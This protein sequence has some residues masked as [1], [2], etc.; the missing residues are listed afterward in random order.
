MRA[1]LGDHPYRLQERGDLGARLRAAFD[2]HFDGG[3][4][5]VVAI[6]A[7]CPAVDAAVI[8]EAERRLRSVDVVI[9]PSE[10]GGYYLI[11]LNE[12][13]PEVFVDV[14]W[15]DAD[16]LRITAARC[17]ERHLSVGLLRTLRDVDTVEDLEA[18]GLERP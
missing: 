16:V 12:P 10:D 3:D 6:G 1:W 11:G 2:A 4:Q 18:L 13:H 15:S 14:P 5:P 7:D 8:Q 17:R 9:G